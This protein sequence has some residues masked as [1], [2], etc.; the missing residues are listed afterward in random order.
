VQEF[1][2]AVELMLAAWTHDEVTYR[3]RRVRVMPRPATRPHPHLLIGGTVPAAARRA[4]RMRLPYS[5]ALYD[6]VLN[7]I[8]L[9]EAA[10]VGY[11]APVPAVGT[12][13]GLVL[14]TPDPDRLWARIG[15][16]LLYDARLYYSWQ[17]P[18]HRSSWKTPAETVDDL[19]ASP[20]YAIV[21]PDQC[22]DLVRQHGAAILH[23]LA[24]GID[25]AVGWETLEL[26]AAE[27]MPALSAQNRAASASA[28]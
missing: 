2:E 21:T 24:A 19:R 15:E 28:P 22:V 6:P 9:A 10:A 18:K 16:R 27:V 7:Q 5:P 12:G 1:E 17:G 13:P 4:A 8:Y 20:N 3:G 14:V 25:P 26:V 23:P 11:D